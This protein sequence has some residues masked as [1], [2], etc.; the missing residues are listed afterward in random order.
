[1]TRLAEMH[2]MALAGD[3]GHEAEDCFSP[4]DCDIAR[5]LDLYDIDNPSWRR[6]VRSGSP[7]VMV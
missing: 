7:V 2:E 1:M 3:H 4:D 6:R 5:Y